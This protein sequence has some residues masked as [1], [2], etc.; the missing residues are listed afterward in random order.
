[1]DSVPEGPKDEAAEGPEATPKDQSSTSVSDD[2]PNKPKAEELPSNPKPAV[3]IA[4]PS[5]RHQPKGKKRGGRLKRKIKFVVTIGILAGLIALI[6]GPLNWFMGKGTIDDEKYQA[7]FLSSGQV[8]FG[9]LH[10]LKDGYFKL[11]GVFYLQAQSTAQDKGNPQQATDQQTPD[12]QLIKLGNEVH[13][14]E[15]EMIISEKQ[16][17]FFENLK[18]DGKVSDSINK[19]NKPR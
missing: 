2:S 6:G 18:K 19:Y 9:K 17:L 7:V 12:V 16:I 13:G 4:S 3:E 1:M 5:V 10:P 14:P 11:T 15:D 8:Y